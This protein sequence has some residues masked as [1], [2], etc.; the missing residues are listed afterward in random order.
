MEDI[1]NWRKSNY[2]SSNGGECV[3]VADNGSRILIRD[4]KNKAGAI[5]RFSPDAWRY[6]AKQIKNASLASDDVL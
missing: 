4:T 5:L 3:E 1:M 6:F 2:S